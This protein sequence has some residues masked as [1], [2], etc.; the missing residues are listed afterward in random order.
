MKPRLINQNELLETRGHLLLKVK[1]IK[2][3]LFSK[4]LSN[5]RKHSYDFCSSFEGTVGIEL[6]ATMDD[7]L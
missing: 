6:L 4:L 2:F 5:A 3:Q 7:D 1:F